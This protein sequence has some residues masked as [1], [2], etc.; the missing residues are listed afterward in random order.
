MNEQGPKLQP[1]A[2]ADGQPGS[3][4]RKPWHAPTV[5]LSK[6]DQ[7]AHLGASSSDATGDS[8]YPS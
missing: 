5:I 1:D 4:G 3:S 8:K 6:M 7:T 2:L